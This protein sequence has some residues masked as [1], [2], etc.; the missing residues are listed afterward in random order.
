M[1]ELVAHEVEI[2]VTGCPEGGESD[3]LVE[4]DTAVYREVLREYRHAIV[5]ASLHE[6]KD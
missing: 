6:A 4:R 2:S 5:D 1:A 3:H